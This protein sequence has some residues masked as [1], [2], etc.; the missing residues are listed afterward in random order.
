MEK[1]GVI[2]SNLEAA[3]SPHDQESGST[4]NIIAQRHNQKELL[5]EPCGK[6]NALMNLFD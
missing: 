3:V 5:P 1:Q 2:L 6:R 4:N